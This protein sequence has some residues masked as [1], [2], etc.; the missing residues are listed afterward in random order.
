VRDA[1]LLAVEDEEEAEAEEHEEAEGVEPE[2]DRVT[3]ARERGI[4]PV[5]VREHRDTTPDD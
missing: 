4:G 5:V 3:S 2:H 1:L